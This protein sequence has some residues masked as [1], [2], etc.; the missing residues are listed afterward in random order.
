MLDAEIAVQAT[1]NDRALRG[2]RAAIRKTV[3]LIIGVVCM[4]HG[5]APLHDDRGFEPLRR[6]FRLHVLCRRP[7]V[8][9]GNTSRPVGLER[10][11]MPTECALGA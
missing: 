2:K 7:I 10:D 5:H 3:D 8:R 11:V 1:H 6:H 9:P 4:E